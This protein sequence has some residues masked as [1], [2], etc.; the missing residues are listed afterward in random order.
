MFPP[1]P[2]LNYYS[3][4]DNINTRIIVAKWWKIE[5][6]TSG[7]ISYGG[8]RNGPSGKGKA[9]LSATNSN[10]TNHSITSSISGDMPIGK[11][12]IGSSLGITIGE[13]K[14]FGVSY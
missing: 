9:R 14:Q 5:S 13:S 12:K 2:I 3:S 7:G 8:W 11:G 4:E 6:K 1:I 10:T